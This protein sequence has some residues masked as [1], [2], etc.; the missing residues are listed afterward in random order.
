MTEETAEQD[1]DI[2][3]ASFEGKRVVIGLGNPF[4]KDDGVGILAAKELRH[5]DLG[6][7]V[8]VYE[9]QTLELSLL[10]QF[11]G[12][13]RVIVVDALRS[14]VTPGTVS[15]F[16]ITP[17]EGPVL[18]LPSLH[19][20][21]LYDMFDL[22]NQ[23][24]MLPCPVTIVGVEPKDCSLGE[25]LTDDVAAAVPKAVELVIEGLRL[26]QQSDEAEGEAATRKSAASTEGG[27][28]HS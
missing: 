18:D 17:R 27:C 13:S 11:R 20:L 7:G 19:A 2:L 1:P 23:A 12:A 14:G 22:A 9:Y 28:L 8:L 3:G 10:W 4:M 25:G 6:V 15:M 5:R 26:P 21:Q 16:A 24:G